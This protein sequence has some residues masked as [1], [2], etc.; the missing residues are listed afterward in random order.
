MVE[1]R[2]GDDSEVAAGPACSPPVG[3]V[4]SNLP[5]QLTSFVGREAEIDAV[6]GLLVE[7]RL[8]ALI[9]SGGC[10]K[11]RLAMQVAASVL[12]RYTDGV[13]WVD[14]APLSDASLVPATL[15]GI[16]G[17]GESPLESIT[18]TAVAYLAS[19]R[20][21]VVLDNC[22]HLIDASAALA[23]RIVVGCPA[24]TVLATSREPLGVPGEAMW[25]VPPLGLPSGDSVESIGE[26]EAVRLF[27][28]RAR[29]SRPS[30]AVTGENAGSVTEICRHLDGIPLAIELAAARSRLL[31]V[32]EIAAGLADRFHLLT[33][34]AR[35][36]LPRQRTLE[37]SVDWSHDLLGD[38]ERAVFRRLAVF[39]GSLTLDAAEAVCAGNGVTPRQ[40]LDRLSGLVDRS[41]VQVVDDTGPQTR[42]RLL[43]TIRAYALHKLVDGGEYD[44]ARERH[45]DFYVSFAERAT[46]GLEGPDLLA[47]LARVDAEI[48]NVRTALGWSIDSAGPDRG[49]RLVGL[50]TLYWFARSDLAI[51]RARLEATLDSARGD[52][53][54][55]VHALGALCVICYRAGDMAEGARYGDEAIA[56]GRRL[57]DAATLGRALH[58]RGWVRCWGEADLQG[59]WSDFEEAAALL[60]HTDDHLFQALNLALFA[61]SYADTSEA[62]RARALLNEGLAITEVVDVPHARCYCLVVRGYLDTL[63]GRL[64]TAAA[65][66][67]EALELADEIGDHY[68]EIFARG[69]LAFT[70][71]FR[72]SYQDGR[73]LCERGLGAA[74]DNRSPM[75]EAVMRMALGHLAFAEDDLDAAAR[76]LEASFELFVRLWRGAA[77]TCRAAQA[78]VALAQS[79][80]GEARQYA[81]EARH[82]GRQT[83]TVGATAWALSAQASLA[84]LDDD[85]HGAED[86]LHDAI[87]LAYQTDRRSFMCDHL[88][89]LAA[90]VADQ[91]RFEEAARLL[92]AAQSLRNAIGSPRFPVHESPHQ[93]CTTVV[94]NALGAP[95]FDEAWAAGAALTLDDAVAYARR[96]RGQRKRPTH[97]WESLTPTELQVVELVAAGLT[98]PQIGDRLFVSKRTV[99]AHLAHVFTKLGVSSRAELAAKAAGRRPI[100]T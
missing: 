15:A 16:L 61:W 86:L 57:G 20:A 30:F 64:D 92:G 100:D 19:R 35:W 9:G 37:A 28:D 65:R 71:L 56:I 52:G 50:L 83:D 81:G 77:A 44:A 12:D 62:S 95:A 76:Q 41:M 3:V 74:L 31:T 91:D 34:G 23:A 6:C 40:V 42:Y 96:G 5:V 66:L 68:A 11:T 93:I 4:A 2:S 38:A 7:G 33:G 13:W 53:L 32:E 88:D 18:D 87:D 99:Q 67:E 84:R 14:L 69:F 55:R 17:V 36:A 58:W 97:G 54:D 98:N 10:G 78:Q 24:A 26:C 51:G 90:A 89:G 49:A 72:G 80:P 82:L 27:V 8:V 45:V 79:R 39:A 43:E 1:A 70:D 85:A 73:D 63:E 29:A 46:A 75:G 47:W 94:R 60:R 22:E 48:D 59:A 25:R 21:L